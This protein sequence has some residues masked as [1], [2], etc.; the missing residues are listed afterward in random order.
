MAEAK[1]D[2]K[3]GAVSF[4]AE[5]SEKWLSGELDKVLAKAPELAA[6]PPAEPGNNDGSGGGGTQTTHA[7]KG[8]LGTLAHFLKEKNATSNQVKKFLATAVYLH[9][10]TGKD[11]LTTGEVKTA[12][13]NANQTK[14]TNPADCLNSNVKKGHAEKDG[15][16][17]FV[18]D[19]GRTSLGA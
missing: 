9:D 12:L 1:I 2:I 14:L 7:T 4:S 6:I 3:I 13:K 5:G 19:P 10:T 11:R 17:F 16:S 8:K 15:G 18:T